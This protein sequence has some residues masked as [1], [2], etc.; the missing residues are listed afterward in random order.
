MGID[1]I[2]F[3]KRREL[4]L[5]QQELA[6]KL[7]VTDKSVY[8]WEKGISSP[9]I[10]SLKRLSE[11]FDIPM[12]TFYS[13]IKIEPINEEPLNT[14]IINKFITL[15]IISIGL[16]FIS[17]VSLLVA[18][19]MPYRSNISFIFQYIGITLAIISIIIF[20]ITYLTF[21]L[22]YKTKKLQNNYRRIK[23]CYLV[24]FCILFIVIGLIIVVL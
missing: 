18:F 1:K 5:T 12:D 11:I 4:S 21:T 19:F 6:H 24:I 16:L 15:S 3:E 17:C 10:H 9:D 7:G 13:E 20:I 14:S 22:S 8:R 2:I 23:L